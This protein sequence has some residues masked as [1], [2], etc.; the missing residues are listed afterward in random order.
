VKQAFLNSRIQGL[1]ECTE[2]DFTEEKEEEEGQKE[3]EIK[4]KIYSKGIMIIWKKIRVYR[5]RG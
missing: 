4:N 1:G 5:V 2:G 3:V